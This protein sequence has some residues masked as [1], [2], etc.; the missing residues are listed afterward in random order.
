M[1][2]DIIVLGSRC[3]LAVNVPSAVPVTYGSLCILL[4]WML[5]DRAVGKARSAEGVAALV[6]P[7]L[8]CMSSQA[9]QPTRH[10]HSPCTSRPCHDERGR[11]MSIRWRGEV[12]SCRIEG[13]AALA[14]SAAGE[15]TAVVE[16]RAPRREDVQ[17]SGND[18]A[19]RRPSAAQV[20]RRIIRLLT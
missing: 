17:A 19:L 10:P 11:R 7:R 6:E 15:D 8:P 14:C 3:G 2:A 4:G 18:G 1:G 16:A 13:V 9:K 12:L 20:K 5:G